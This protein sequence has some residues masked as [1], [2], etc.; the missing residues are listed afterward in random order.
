MK[1]IL[2]EQVMATSTCFRQRVNLPSAQVADLSDDELLAALA[3]EIEPFSGIPRADSLIAWKMVGGGETSRRVYDVVQIR[4]S[5]LGRVVVE[6]RKAGKTVRAVTAVPEPT[7][8]ETL[9]TLPWIEVRRGGGLGA[10]RPFVLL[11]AV[12]CLL[13][14][15]LAWDAFSLSSRESV[16][17]KEVECRRGLQAEKDQLT[18][19]LAN[20]RQDTQHVQESRMAM[21]RAQQN[22]E[23]LRAAWQILLA[24]IPAACQDDAVVKSIKSAGAFSAELSGVALS[25]EAAGRVCV[26]LSEALKA[27]KSAWRVRPGT[28]GAAAAG[29]TV[30]FSCQLDFDPEGQF[31]Q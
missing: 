5:D 3:F 13:A 1:K 15:A 19:K 24:A 12:G 26:R 4:K 2:P 22:A 28:V 31:R 8:G 18:R 23:V 25:A 20:I 9:D 17:T 30:G 7:V 10:K 27:P 29:G 11:V 14:G 6:G 16:L 21:A